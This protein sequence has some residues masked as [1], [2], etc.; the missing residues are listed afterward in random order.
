MKFPH[1]KENRREKELC[2]RAKR[3]LKDPTFGNLFEEININACNCHYDLRVPLE[4]ILNNKTKYL[5]ALN[6]SRRHLGG[7]QENLLLGMMNQ[8]DLQQHLDLTLLKLFCTHI[9]QVA[10]P[11]L[12]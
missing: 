4:G 6:L 9:H 5:Q 11:G 1:S 7:N 12:S 2:T 8:L 3:V 10:F